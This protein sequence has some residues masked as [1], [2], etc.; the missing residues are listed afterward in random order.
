MFAAGFWQ[1]EKG[2][3]NG[4]AES[5]KTALASTPRPQLEAQLAAGQEILECYRLLAKTGDNIVGELIR[6]HETF[7]QWNHYPDGDAY[8]GET[9]SQYYYHSHREDREEHGHFHVFLRPKGMPAGIRPAP[10]PDFEAPEDSNGA[11]SHLIAISMDAYGF[12]TS[13]FTTNRWV[14]GEAWYVAKDVCQM[15]ARFEMDQA[16][17]SWPVNRWVTAMVRLFQR[18]IFDLI[19]QRDLAVE[20]WEK[21]HPDRNVYEDRELETTSE[22]DISVD[23]KLRQ[24]ETVLAQQ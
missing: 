18:E 21:Q 4:M 13:L 24:L 17:P 14:T 1:L 19:A 9:H 22:M 6:G 12:P 3:E 16:R 15:I 11:L 5:E 8:D 10:L 20:A 7:Y 23:D 2:V